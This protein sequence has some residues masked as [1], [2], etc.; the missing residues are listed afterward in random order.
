MDLT[1][2][3]TTQY[4]DAVK[5]NVTGS[6]SA[7]ATQITV[8]NTSLFF[9][10]QDILIFNMTGTYMGQYETNV[11]SSIQSSNLILAEPLSK[12]YTAG[13]QVI[14]FT[15]YDSVEVINAGTITCS[16]WNGT[17]GGVVYIK[18]NTLVV[19][20]SSKIDASNKGYVNAS[21]PGAGGST[22]STNGGGGG[23]AYGGDGSD[24]NKTS[25]G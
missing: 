14:A 7:G 18:A 13:A 17:V 25:G 4:V 15:Q 23:G 8:A 16:G 9:A 24:G 5:S 1:V 6:H 21:G 11:I 12:S 3:G 19:D 22:S 2:N 20:S 10:G